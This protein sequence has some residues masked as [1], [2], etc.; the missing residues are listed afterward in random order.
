MLMDLEPTTPAKMATASM[1][2]YS[3]FLIL[4]PWGKQSIGNLERMACEGEHN[5]LLL[6]RIL[7]LSI[8]NS[9]F[10]F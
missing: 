8:S 5:L 7:C 10:D 9:K 1:K 2:G 4:S 6:T 3:L